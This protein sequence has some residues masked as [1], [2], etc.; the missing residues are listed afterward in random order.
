MTA[1]KGPGR[2]W[3][4]GWPWQPP[5]LP[6]SP[7]GRREESRGLPG[8]KR[9]AELGFICTGQKS[10]GLHSV[11]LAPAPEAAGDGGSCNPLPV[12]LPRPRPCPGEPVQG[13]WQPATQTQLWQFLNDSSICVHAARHV[14]APRGQEPASLEPP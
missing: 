11:S 5:D 6:D 14:D 9:A 12:P 10:R 13:R 7:P 3:G 1:L 2:P 8:Q 4:S